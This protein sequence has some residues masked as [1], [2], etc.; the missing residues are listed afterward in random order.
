MGRSPSDGLLLL[1]PG[2]YHTLSIANL[3]PPLNCA[4]HE[5]NHIQLCNLCCD[6]AT[7]PSVKSGRFGPLDSV[8]FAVARSRRHAVSPLPGPSVSELCARSSREARVRAGARLAE[9]SAIP[10]EEQPTVPHDPSHQI[11]TAGVQV[12]VRE[13]GPVARGL[14][15][16]RTT[17]SW[18]KDLDPRGFTPFKSSILF[19]FDCADSNHSSGRLLMNAGVHRRTVK[20]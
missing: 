17:Q 12:R 6:L 2:G 19:T 3:V 7:N 11:P 15:A 20:S 18:K 5:C 1:D 9:F 8:S 16:S 4:H 10:A 13:G 14:F